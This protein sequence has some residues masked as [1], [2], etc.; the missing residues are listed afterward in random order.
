MLKHL[1]LIAAVCSVVLVAG[2]GI[3]PP[4]TPDAPAGPSTGDVGVSYRFTAVTIDPQNLPL[5]TSSTGA[6]DVNPSGASTYRA[7]SR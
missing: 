5:D 4:V 7:A 3:L 6:T 2:C 1:S